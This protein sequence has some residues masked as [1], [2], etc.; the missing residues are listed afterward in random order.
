MGPVPVPQAGSMANDDKIP[1]FSERVREQLLLRRVLVLDGVL[2]EPYVRDRPF[3]ACR[4]SVPLDPLPRGRLCGG[5]Y[6]FAGMTDAR[7]F[8][9]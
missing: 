8:I 3:R 9:H 6:E 2:D 1:L 7:L 5:R 4:H